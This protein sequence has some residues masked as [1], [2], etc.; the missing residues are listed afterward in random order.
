MQFQPFE[1]EAVD[2]QLTFLYFLGKA[3]KAKPREV[4]SKDTLAKRISYCI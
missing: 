1:G 3:K 2:W 4:I